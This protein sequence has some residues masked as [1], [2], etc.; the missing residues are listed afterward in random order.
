MIN[1]RNKPRQGL[2]IS[3]APRSQELVDFCGIDFWHPTLWGAISVPFS[4]TF[5]H[6]QLKIFAQ[7]V[8]CAETKVAFENE[9][10]QSEGWFTK[11]FS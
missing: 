5:D 2:A 9:G 11:L 10:G 6:E 1:D 8:C 3:F 7:K 4:N